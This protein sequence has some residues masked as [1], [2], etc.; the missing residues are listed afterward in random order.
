LSVF[1]MNSK[2]EE[3][4][5]FWWRLVDINKYVYRKQYFRNDGCLL[6]IIILFSISAIKPNFAWCEQIIV[7]PRS[8]VLQIYEL[9]PFLKL[10][11]CCYAKWK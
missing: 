1:E 4:S 9:L 6:K 11:F 7:R 8:T 3:I 5:G 2:M 10:E